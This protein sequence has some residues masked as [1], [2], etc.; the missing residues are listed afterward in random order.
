MYSYR[1]NR[2][3]RVSMSELDRCTAE[4]DSPRRCHAREEEREHRD[5]G[6]RGESAVAQSSRSRSREEEE[7]HE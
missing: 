6:R 3:E 2:H 5:D 4:Q 1:S 7:E